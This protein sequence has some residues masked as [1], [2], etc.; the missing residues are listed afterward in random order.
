MSFVP[1]LILQVVIFV[2]MVVGLR[3]LISRN[4]TDASA[5][6]Q[7]LNAE[8][9]K[10]HDELKQRLAEAER[11]Y[12]EQMDRAKAEAGQLVVQ[13]RQEAESSK[14]K[15]LDDTRSE[16]ERIVQQGLESR[17]ALR[18]EIEQMMEHRAIE[19]ACEL[20][21]E[22]LPG[23]LRRDIQ[24]QWLDE[25][26]HNGLTQLDGLRTE[27]GIQEASVVSAFPLNDTQRQLLKERLKKKFGRDVSLTETTDDALVAGLVITLGSVVL[28]GSLASKLREAARHAQHTG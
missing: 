7:G 17:D 13:A 27:E 9:T 25:L 14:A 20:I 4:L 24:L 11:Q 26:L 1:F 5:H 28:D 15:L 12:A 2:V 23:Q 16:S 22:V 8:Y 10:R 21:Q 19:R 18:K 6:L 3:R